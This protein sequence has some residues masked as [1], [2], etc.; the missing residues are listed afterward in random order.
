MRSVAV[1]VPP[2]TFLYTQMPRER[3]LGPQIRVV[4]DRIIN[5]DSPTTSPPGLEPHDY[6]TSEAPVARDE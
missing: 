6:G 5:S 3:S 2:L 4:T 1:P